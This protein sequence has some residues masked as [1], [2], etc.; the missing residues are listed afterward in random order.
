MAKKIKRTTINPLLA[1]AGLGAT[2][3]V[4]DVSEGQDEGMLR[5]GIDPIKGWRSYPNVSGQPKHIPASP[6]KAE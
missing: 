2:G 4:T 6:D 3:E 5:A 1:L